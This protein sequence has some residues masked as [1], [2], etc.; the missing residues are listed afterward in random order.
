MNILKMPLWL[1][2]IILRIRLKKYEKNPNKLLEELK[3]CGLEKGENMEEDIKI[4]EHFINNAGI[5]V[6]TFELKEAIENLINKYK[7]QEKT[8]EY[9]KMVELMAYRL[10]EFANLGVLIDCPAEYDGIKDLRNCP[11]DKNCVKC[12]IDYFKKKAK[13]E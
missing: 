9:R 1:A 4:L 13:G 2:K 3:E 6:K 8:N 10:N 12:I 11:R 5:E 7:E